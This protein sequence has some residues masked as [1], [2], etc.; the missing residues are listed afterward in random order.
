ML[1]AWGHIMGMHLN[2]I[3]N[4]NVSHVIFHCVSADLL[5]ALGGAVPLCWDRLL[6]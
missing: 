3:L 5:G 6:L 4:R 1:G 2:S